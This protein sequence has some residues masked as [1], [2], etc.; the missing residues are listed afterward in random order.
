MARP[1]L[2]CPPRPGKRCSIGT[3]PRARAYPWRRGRPNAYRTLVSEL[4]LQQTQAPRVVPIFEAFVGA[5]PTVRAL[6]GA[7]RADV[8]RAWAGLGYNRRAVSLHR[9]AQAVVAQHGGRVPTDR[10]DLRASAR[11]RAVHGGGGRF[12]R[13]RRARRRD[14]RERAPDRGAGRVRAGR[15][16]RADRRHRRDRGEV[17]RSP[18]SRRLEPGVDGSRQGALP[19]GPALRRVPARATPADSSGRAARR[20]RPARR[21]SRSRDRCVRS[22]GGVVDVLRARPSAGVAGLARSTGFDARSDHGGARRAGAR[23][24]RSALRA[25]VSAPGLTSGGRP[26]A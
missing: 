3:A 11:R 13:R 21:Q 23:R 16:G 9:A 17:G 26:T 6:A 10:A 4:M 7:S 14:R 12:D 22:R 25:L 5:F 24:G 15:R 19:G 18:G 8:L 2:A 20:R 1:S